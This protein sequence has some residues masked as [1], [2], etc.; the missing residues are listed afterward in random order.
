MKK[1]IIILV[2][3]L[4]VGLAS[5]AAVFNHY[6]SQWSIRNSDSTVPLIIQ[7]KRGS[8]VG[9]IGA[10]LKKNRLIGDTFD[11]KLYSR[12]SG[13]GTRYKSGV[14]AIPANATILEIAELLS[15]GKTA[16]VKV[17]IPEGR[18]S[19]EISAI[20]ANKMPQ[21]D[22]AR[23]ENAVYDAQ[24]AKVL[25]IQS[26]SV[27]GYLYPDTYKFPY[28]VT[29]REVIRIMVA[30]FNRVFKTLDSEKSDF[31]KKYGKNGVVTFASVVE[32]EAGV[33]NERGR[34]AGVFYN[35]LKRGMPLGADPTVRYIFRNLT[36]PIYRSQLRSD[37][38]F[39]TRKNRGLMPHAVSNPGKD[40][41]KAALF[42][43]TNRDLYF[44]AK[45]NGS[46]E[47]FFSGSLKMHNYYKNVAAANRKKYAIK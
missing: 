4:A 2:V 27:E 39:N 41:L 47:H 22:S 45:D 34:I 46:M 21:I 36:G 1:V 11:F 32:E 7:I 13:L 9:Q 38:P 24:F 30:Q 19:W 6:Q 26:K 43:E 35:R 15:H 40:A 25:G 23:F 10:L 17:T 20:L 14:Y 42:P 29:E 37:S 18:V 44:V 16:T 5:L 33:P 12:Y 8:A 31:F 3:I 28:G